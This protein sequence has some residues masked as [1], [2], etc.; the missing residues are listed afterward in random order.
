MQK[1]TTFLW[2]KDQAEDAAKFY[3]S[4]FPGSKI[5]AVTRFPDGGLGPAG[6]VMTVAFELDGQTFVALNGGPFPFSPAISLAVNVDTQEELDRYWSKLSEGGDPR[7][8][9]CG[10]LA[11]RYGLSWQVVPTFID[12][13]LRDD[14]AA[15]VTRVT[16]ALLAMKKLDIAALKRAYE[17]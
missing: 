9:Q 14:D 17:G 16:Q 15:K 5:T 3:T 4:V 8:Q 2:F 6:G 11:D 1:I 12:K 13:M 10:W 7:A